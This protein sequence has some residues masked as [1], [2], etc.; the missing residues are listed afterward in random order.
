M[1]E[2]EHLLKKLEAIYDSMLVAEASQQGYIETA[3]DE[4]R[5]S[6]INLVNYLALRAK[7][8]THLQIAL[9]SIGLS[10]LAS[11]ESHIK[12]QIAEVIKWLGGKDITLPEGDAAS[13][14]RRLQK[15]IDAL[16]GRN[17]GNADMPIM[18]TFDTGF[19]DD[20]ELICELLENGMQV[21]RINCAHDN[22][23]VWTAMITKLREACQ[24]SGKSCKLY[25]D[26]AGPK[27][28]I[29]VISRK[30]DHSKL[31]VKLDMELILTDLARTADS[32]KKFLQCTL[33][34]IVEQLKPG[35]RVLIDDGL[36]EAQVTHSEGKLAVL[37]VVRISGGKSVIKSEKGMNFPDTHFNVDTL[38]AK[39]KED[40]LF[41]V[42]HADMVGFSFVNSAADMAYLQQELRS[43]QKSSF[44]IVA[45][46]ETRQAFENLPAIILQGMQRGVTGVMVAR[47]DLAM[48]IGFE[49]LSEVQDEILWICDAA[50]VPVIWAT[51]VLERMQK[52]GLAS[53][54]EIT[55]AAHAA[56]ADC[57]MLNKGDH[58][59]AV[60]KMLRDILSRS[61]RNNYKNRRIFRQLKIAADFTKGS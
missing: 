39:D 31:R 15:N 45:K 11:S 47:G 40:L 1:K 2:K 49:R 29:K 23:R 10:S 16:F 6:A 14:R 46:I 4:Q 7:D 50:H 20:Q 22:E 44:P 24:Q 28:R 51:Q 26:L 43:L 37:R 41:I 35:H 19:A 21:A 32:P 17:E 52:Q 53:R 18:V 13:G 55:D 34:G 33:P 54:G 25:M 5:P 60:L 12:Y 9:H 36:F 61:R 59:V 58:T 38:T 56:D 30:N 42:A 57:V 8:I 27:I 3:V 48:E